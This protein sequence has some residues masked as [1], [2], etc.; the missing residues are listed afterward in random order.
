MAKEAHVDYDFEEDI[1]YISTGVAVQ[2]SLEFDQFII[3][4]SADDK[5]VGLEIM[6]ASK[7]LENFFESEIDK[8]R[9]EN[10][11]SARFSVIGQKE[12]SIIKI[13]MKI[14]LVKGI[15]EDR[16]FTA[17]APAVVVA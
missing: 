10:I 7:Y 5:I 1:L 4:F 3:D 15:F 6:N 12:F 16:L 8:K 2:D 9:L 14:P 17:T 11:K 13:V